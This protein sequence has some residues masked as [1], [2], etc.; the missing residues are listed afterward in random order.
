MSS[1]ALKLLAASGA[2]DSATYVDDVFSTFLFSGTG[3]NQTINN[4]VDLSG[5]GGLVW[6]KCRNNVNW[7]YW[8]DT[9]RGAGNVMYSNSTNAQ[10]STGTSYLYAFNNNGF[11][12]GPG[13]SVSGQNHVGWSFRKAPGFFDVVT[14]TG[15]GTAGRT[16]SHN[17]GSVPGMIIVKSTT[18]V[19]NWFVY[20]RS[21]GAT[22]WMALNQTASAYTSA[23]P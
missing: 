8:F 10:G 19:E 3:S 18:S 16:V 15:N 21:N 1:S 6:G 22:K 12:M 7:H 2:T 9:E 14:Y 4:G 13:I 5:E 20:H 11:S 23:G 17:L